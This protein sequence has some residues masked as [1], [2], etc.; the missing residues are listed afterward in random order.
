MPGCTDE[1]AC[2]YDASATVDDGSCDVVMTLEGTVAGEG[3][4]PGSADIAVTG[5]SGVYSFS[6]TDANGAGVSSDE[7]V[8]LASGTYNVL[9]TDSLGC[10]G[11]LEG[12]VIDNTDNVIDFLAGAGIYPNPTAEWPP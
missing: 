11:I 9:V 8:T 7:D 5:G 3:S 12:I 2:N 4:T 10:S 6:W 1:N